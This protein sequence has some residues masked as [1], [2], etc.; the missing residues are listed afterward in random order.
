V[1][2]LAYGDRMSDFDTVLERLL[3]DPSFAAD[4]SRDPDEALSGYQLGGDEIDLL[5]SQ[6]ATAD[7]DSV[8]AK[9]EGRMTKS[10]TFGLFSSVGDGL[11]QWSEF[12]T[13]A[14]VAAR[15]S[16]EAF[17]HGGAGGGVDVPAHSAFGD[18]PGHDLDD[19]PGVSRM[20]EKPSTGM[21]DAETFRHAANVSHVEQVPPAAHHQ[22]ADLEELKPP[23]GYH[24]QVDADGDGHWDKATYV[25]REDGGVD[26]LVDLNHDG[27]V[28]FVGRDLDADWTV[29]EADISSKRDGVF[30]K[31]MY[32][33][34]GNGWLD[35]TVWH[36]D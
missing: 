32:D 10:S 17:S 6:V 29:D 33:D 3:S 34:N 8:V 30:D 23:K 31:T 14:G 22:Q 5:R 11:G 21:G 19:L 12:G 18:A 7:T 20:G 13:A 27:K 36:N 25:G 35:R 16:A 15:H 24:N 4:L 9:V 2:A 26:I 1:D 28:D